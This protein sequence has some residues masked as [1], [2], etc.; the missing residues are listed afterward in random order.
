M[1]KSG[2]GHPHQNPLLLTAQKSLADMMRY[3]VEFG[4]I[5]SSH[6]R[7]NVEQ[8]ANDE[9]EAAKFFTRSSLEVL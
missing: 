9:N 6:T 1:I 5:P 4:M 7:I 3:A 2:S 8:R